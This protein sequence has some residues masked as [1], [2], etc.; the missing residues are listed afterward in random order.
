MAEEEPENTAPPSTASTP[1]VSKSREIVTLT[2][3]A[4]PFSYAHLE[5][6]SA[7]VSAKPTELDA[8]QVRSY[9]TSAL[10][11][12]LGIAGT[13]ISLD[14]LKVEGSD[15]WLR[16]PRDD[17]SAFSAAITA[18]QGTVDNGAHLTLRIKACSDWLGSLVGRAD[19][20]KLWT[21]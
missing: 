8:L 2:I 21:S 19:E 16:I 14:I 11:Q 12:F 1:K 3:K 5:V 9:C 13:A 20:E 15:C 17:L 4:P 7:D 6:L 10:R 18:W